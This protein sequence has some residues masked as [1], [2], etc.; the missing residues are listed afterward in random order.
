MSKI[1][2]IFARETKSYFL[3]P[4]AY[5][6]AAGFT[7]FSSASFY[8]RA[9]NFP[10]MIAE[11]RDSGF[12]DTLKQNRI[13][14]F[15]LTPVLSDAGYVLMFLI[16]IITMRLWSEEKRTR[17]DE[18]LLTSPI[19]VFQMIIGKYI[20][21]MVFV[22]TLLAITLVY[23]GFVF[24]YA[25]P[26]YGVTFSSYLAVIFFISGAVAIGLFTST[27][28][29]NQIIASVT[30]LI[31]ELTLATLQGVG[32][33]LDSVV[34]GNVIS[35]TSWQQHMAD[36]FDGVIR[37]GDL[38]FFVSMTVFWLFLAHQ[39]IESTRWR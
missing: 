29:E 23:T 16:P 11:A 38:V 7:L 8:Y 36:L 1:W 15:V 17:T 39:S 21:G 31:I 37:S 32:E 30:C 35:Y 6:V 10:K 25:S 5:V 13:N 26:D 9:S 14:Y 22:L 19:S 27:L 28:T 24:Y 4:V 3:S 34:W 33:S 12:L 18:L 20:A 2:S